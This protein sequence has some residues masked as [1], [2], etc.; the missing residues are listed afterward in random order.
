MTGVLI[1]EK[2]DVILHIVTENS[3]M[4]SFRLDSSGLFTFAIHF[5]DSGA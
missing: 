3:F 2:A 4:S 5:A 1:L